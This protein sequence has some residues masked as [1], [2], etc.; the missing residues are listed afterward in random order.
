MVQLQE[1]LSCHFVDHY[2]IGLG[3]YS[4]GRFDQKKTTRLHLDGGPSCSFLLLGYE[5]SLVTSRFLVADYSRC[6]YELELFPRQFLDQQNPMLTEA[7]REAIKP[8]TEE[9]PGWDDA[10][11]RLV[12]I[13]NS[14]LNQGDSLPGLG[15][16][17]GAE[18]LHIPSP[19]T[20]RI[21]NSTMIVPTTASPP[22]Q[23][24]AVITFLE[25]TQISG[26][27]L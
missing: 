3:F 13:N 11:P 16:L 4:M 23:S 1:S 6:A 18:I 24:Q 19:A 14:S 17:H 2:G 10:I 9:V 27:I 26:Q 12:V 20:P 5:P 25:T 21:I 7:G 15:V 8:W 22:G